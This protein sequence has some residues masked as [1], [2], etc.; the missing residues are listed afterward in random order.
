[1]K[2]DFNRNKG[3]RARDRRLIFEEADILNNKVQSPYHTNSQSFVEFTST[4]LNN[5][6]LKDHHHRRDH[7]DLL[8]QSTTHALSKKNE[9]ELQ[10]SKIEIKE[11]EYQSS[12]Q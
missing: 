4:E 5:S 6:Q 12:R 8:M 7:L 11:L 9:S 3:N 10:E 2:L 1:M